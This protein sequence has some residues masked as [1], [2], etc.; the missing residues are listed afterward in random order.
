[1]PIKIIQ[2]LIAG[3]L[4]LLIA[5]YIPSS[6]LRHLHSFVTKV[7]SKAVPR[8]LRSWRPP[9]GGGPAPSPG[10]AGAPRRP[11]TGAPECFHIGNAR[12]SYLVPR[13]GPPSTAR[14]RR[15]VRSRGPHATRHGEAPPLCCP[16]GWADGP[17]SAPHIYERYMCAPLRHTVGMGRVGASGAPPPISAGPSLREKV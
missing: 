1:M 16:A 8:G 12:I 13:S 6:W 5:T 14:Q 7:K 15:G 2:A 11:P 17:P 9:E 4:V 10:A 3:M